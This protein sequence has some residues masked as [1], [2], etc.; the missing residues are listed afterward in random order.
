M[1]SKLTADQRAFVRENPFYA[2]VTT[3]REDGSPHS[4]VVWI[5]EEDGAIV[6]N[7]AY[8]R[9]KTKDLDHD[10]RAAVAVLDPADPY[11]WI[12]ASGPVTLSTED[13]NAVIDRLS[14][15]YTGHDYQSHREG[16]TRVTVRMAPD[17][18]TAHNI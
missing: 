12:S 13:G 1:A 8:P 14:R 3:L 6:F 4:T 16:E 15:K 17:H 5:D 9:Q 11:R 7:T 18:V 2:V 10:G